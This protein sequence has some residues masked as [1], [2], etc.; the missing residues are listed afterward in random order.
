MRKTA[1]VFMVTFCEALIIIGTTY[2]ARGSEQVSSD[3]GRSGFGSPPA[4][5]VPSLAPSGF[6]TNQGKSLKHPE[7][8][9]RLARRAEDTLKGVQQ[10]LAVHKG[11]IREW[12]KRYFLNFTNSTD[13]TAYICSFYSPT[14]QLKQVN[15]IPG[16]ATNKLL[17]TLHKNGRLWHFADSG[18]DEGIEFFTNG[19]PRFLYSRPEKDKNYSAR[20]NEKSELV[21][22]MT[23]PQLR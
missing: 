16:T 8:P 7:E 1:L 23:R 5:H 21:N 17:I 14:G 15:I 4:S 3:N 10:A 19:A 22:Q 13:G 12:N 20:F 11:P 18:R 2:N 6:S 9:A